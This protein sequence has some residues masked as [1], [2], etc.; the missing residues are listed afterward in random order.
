MQ[1]VWKALAATAVLATAGLGIWLTNEAAHASGKPQAERAAFAAVEGI[2]AEASGY[3]VVEADAPQERR[4]STAGLSLEQKKWRRYDRNR[5]GAISLDEFHASRLKSF[6]KLDANGDGMVSPAEYCSKI[7][8]RFVQSDADGNRKLN[9]TEFAAATARKRR[10]ED[11][12]EQAR[13]ETT[14]KDS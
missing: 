14:D 1:L 8:Q 6:A 5:D 13:A 3:R 11:S 7:D 12:A 2:P 4:E 10:G 9:A